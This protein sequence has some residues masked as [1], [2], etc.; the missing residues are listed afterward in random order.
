MN[1][2]RV[3]GR[4]RLTE[5][6]QRWS[7][8][9]RDAGAAVLALVYDDL[10]EMARRQLRRERRGHTLQATALVHEAFLRLAQA[11]NVHF[12]NRVHFASLFAGIMRRVLVD[13][14]R[15]RNALKRGGKRVS[16]TLEEAVLGAKDRPPDLL[17]LDEAL[18]RLA[19]RDAQKAEI[20]ELRFFGGLTLEETAQALK[21]SS[22]T[23][24][25]QWRLARAW[26]FKELRGVPAAPVQAK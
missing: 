4:Q 3:V 20:V 7:D 15:E 14:A 16:V 22:A 17:A 10:R 13:H 9:D 26:L 23:I 2:E 25:R 8:G 24:S 21:T 19:A 1:T 18:T 6:L 5:V 11:S 12:Q